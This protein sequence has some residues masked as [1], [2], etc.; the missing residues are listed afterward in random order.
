MNFKTAISPKLLKSDKR[1]IH[2]SKEEH[3]GFQII[4]WT[5]GLGASPHWLRTLRQNFARVVSVIA[6][7]HVLK[8]TGPALTQCW[9]QWDKRA[10][11]KNWKNGKSALNFF[12]FFG[13]NFWSSGTSRQYSVKRRQMLCNVWKSYSRVFFT[14]QSAG[15]FRICLN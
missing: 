13:P 11:N 7:Q 1:F 5:T 9:Y 10:T 8:H 4:F 3:Q 12:H 2:R 14:I 6:F 15:A